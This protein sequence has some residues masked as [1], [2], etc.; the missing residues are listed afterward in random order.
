MTECAGRATPFMAPRW[1][2]ERSL[3]DPV[4][5]PVTFTYIIPAYNEAA[6]LPA[7][8]GALVRRLDAFPGSEIV[9]V[10]NGSTDSTFDVAS[11][12]VREASPS[13]VRVRVERSEKGLGRALRRGVDVAIC[14]WICCT[15]ADL[16]FGFT[17]LD[18][19]LALQGSV[20]LVLGSKG[21]P[22]SVARR[23]PL[24]QLMTATFRLARRAIV[25]MTVRDPQGTLF[26]ERSLARELAP[27]TVDD[28]FLF[29]TEL[30]AFAE[31]AGVEVVEVPVV[32]DPLR[33]GSTV[34]PIH[35][36][37]LMLSGLFRLRRRLAARVAR[38]GRAQLL[39][40]SPPRWAASVSERAR[41]PIVSAVTTIVALMVGFG[42]VLLA[43]LTVIAITRRAAALR[44][45]ASGPFAG[46]PAAAAYA[47]SA[48]VLV[49]IAG[50]VAASRVARRRF[51]RHS[52]RA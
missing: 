10:E 28:G 50:V 6:T 17:D 27:L 3:V 39:A 46:R 49:I 22:D 19:F 14:Q 12:L 38:D 1:E 35:D 33:D 20:R 9:I 40:A 32:L 13:Q 11:G 45:A 44:S 8:V 31:A 30:V 41:L 42:A 37:L 43:P 29:P 15:A 16:P 7:T 26:I 18:G 48:G 23:S 52:D 2:R 47:V 24:R 34:R 5:P 21:H 51:R 4:P 36:S 25:G